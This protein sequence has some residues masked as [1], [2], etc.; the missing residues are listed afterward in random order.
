MT[1]ALEALEKPSSDESVAE[2]PAKQPSGSG[3]YEVHDDYAAEP[4]ATQLS[5]CFEVSDY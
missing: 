4:P 5:G 1:R 3:C 2:S